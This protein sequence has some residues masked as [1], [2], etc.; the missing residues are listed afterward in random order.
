MQ[1]SVTSP[2]HRTQPLLLP[3]SV[4]LHSR[5]IALLRG[6]VPGLEGG[7]LFIAALTL[8][9]STSDRLGAVLSLWPLGLL[10]GVAGLLLAR[11]AFV[12]RARLVVEDGGVRIEHPGILRTPFV[13]AG[14][15][16]RL[17]AVADEPGG[18][19]R[20]HPAG[21]GRFTLGE[22]SGPGTPR[23]LYRRGH[24]SPFP[25]LG[26]AAEDPNVALL[27]A[28]PIVFSSARRTLRLF[29]SMG[30]THIVRPKQPTSGLLLRVQDPQAARTAFAARGVLG[31][32]TA[33][34]VKRVAPDVVDY[35]RARTGRARAYL[36]LA[37]V[38]T[39][40]V[41]APLVVSGPGPAENK[42]V[43]RRAGS[44]DGQ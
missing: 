26:H 30:P 13:I 29:A 40:N 7:L 41:A 11:P 18:A 24:N 27:F 39:M 12:R 33:D 21:A 25:L 17:V 36:S 38:V 43:A 10:F 16:I 37:M 6:L 9:G 4:T 31:T 32:I 42:L 8:E 28:R 1:T 34:D 15:D 5:S 23:W 22:E 20:W 35:N 14:P 2:A 3:L 19:R 44:G